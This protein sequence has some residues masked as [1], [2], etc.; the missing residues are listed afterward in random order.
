MNKIVY[1]FNLDVT[2]SESQ[3]CLSGFCVGENNARE[4]QIS[5]MNGLNA[6]HF[7]GKEVVSMFVLRPSDTIP[8]IGLCSLDGDIIIY[9]ILQSDVEEEGICTL[10][11]KVQNE[12]EITYGAQFCIQVTNPNCDESTVPSDPQFTILEDLITKEQEKSLDSEAWAVGT[13]DGEAVTED[14]PCYHNNA[15]YYSENAETL[16][17]TEVQKAESWATGTKGGVPVTSGD[18]TYQNNSKYYAENAKSIVEEAVSD[19]E[20]KA[21]AQADIATT[22]ATEASASASNAKTSETNAKASENNAKASETNANASAENAKTSETNASTYASNAETSASNASTSETNASTYA[23][24]AKVSENNA[25]IYDSQTYTFANK[26]SSS[27]TN[28]KTYETNANNSA[29]ISEGYAQGTQ[30]GE[31]VTS[32]SP[33]YHNNAKFYCE[34]AST[35]QY[36]VYYDSTAN[37]IVFENATIGNEVEY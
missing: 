18:E 30:S 34:K 15:K 12:T 22:K 27:A 23:K 31:A 11:V 16:V 35:T 25:R 3:K 28:A 17:M 5:L 33:Y 2:R 10:T 37:Q 19:A 9:K 7:T 32:E 13:R 20:E 14:D 8:S 24:K 1:K 4:L 36:T 26:A 6:I 29:L 21:K